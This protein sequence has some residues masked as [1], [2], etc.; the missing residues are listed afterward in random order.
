MKVRGHRLQGFTMMELVVVLAIL[1]L[2]LIM[3]VPR[4][5]LLY[6]EQLLGQQARLLEKE[7]IEVRAMARRSGEVASLSL[8]DAQHYTIQSGEKVLREEA[9]LHPSL[10]LSVEGMRQMIRFRPK[11]TSYDKTTLELTSKHGGVRHVV[12]N[13]LGRIKVTA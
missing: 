7:L 8:K 9:L 11:G 2:M 10:S 13:N 12:V 5:Q 4:V 3:L 6:E 1:A